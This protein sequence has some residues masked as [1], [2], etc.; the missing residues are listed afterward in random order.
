MPS[1]ESDQVIMSEELFRNLLERAEKLLVPLGVWPSHWNWWITVFNIVS[2]LVYSVLVLIKN[3]RNPERESIEN[4]FTLANGGLITVVYFT[5]MLLKKEK[6][7]ELYA[8][9]KSEKQLTLTSDERKV[10]ISVGKE[11]YKITTA[12]LYFL[13]TAILIRFLLP[14]AKFTYLKV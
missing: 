7:A 10:V 6:C 14:T 4:A 2:L 13:P 9:I 5:T 8:Y 1:K 12:F 11:F 3:L